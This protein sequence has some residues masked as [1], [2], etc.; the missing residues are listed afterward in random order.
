MNSLWDLVTQGVPLSIQET[1]E[2]LTTIDPVPTSKPGGLGQ[3]HIRSTARVYVNTTIYW[4]LLLNLGPEIPP[5]L[6]SMM[7]V[8]GKQLESWRAVAVRLIRMSLSHQP[9]FSTPTL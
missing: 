6:G 4:D 3:V 1:P 5:L 2:A 9:S 8:Q 7:V